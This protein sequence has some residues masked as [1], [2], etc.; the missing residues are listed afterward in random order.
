MEEPSTALSDLR[1]DEKVILDLIFDTGVHVPV[2]LIPVAKA[3]CTD[4]LL[5][6]IFANDMPED[7]DIDGALQVLV[8]YKEPR[9]RIALP[10]LRDALVKKLLEESLPIESEAHA[11]RRARFEFFFSD[12]GVIEQL[13][14]ET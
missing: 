4:I 5:G 13:S 12:K 2:T 7:G 8:S 11:M 14:Q 1:I 9:L 3:L 6:A 10:E